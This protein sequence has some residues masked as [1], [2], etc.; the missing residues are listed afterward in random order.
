MFNSLADLLCINDK[1]VVYI[2]ASSFSGDINDRATVEAH[3]HDPG[4]GP[5]RINPE[6]AIGFNFDHNTNNDGDGYE[7]AGAD[8]DD[9]GSED[10]RRRNDSRQSVDFQPDVNESHVTMHGHSGYVTSGSPGDGDDDYESPHGGGRGD[11]RSLPPASARGVGR[12]ESNSSSSYSEG[13]TYARGGGL[14]RNNSDRQAG[15]AGP[16]GRLA[17]IVEV[18]SPYE[19]ASAHGGSSDAAN[20][21]GLADSM[22]CMHGAGSADDGANNDNRGGGKDDEEV[23]ELLDERNHTAADEYLP[24]LERGRRMSAPDAMEFGVERTLTAAHRSSN[25]AATA[26]N[27][28]HVQPAHLR[29]ISVPPN[30][31]GGG[32]GSG[33]AGLSA[34]SSGG[35]A[36]GQSTPESLIASK[37]EALLARLERLEARTRELDATGGVAAGARTP[38]VGKLDA[39]GKRLSLVANQKL[40]RAVHKLVLIN[41]FNKAALSNPIAAGS[42]MSMRSSGSATSTATGMRGGLGGSGGTRTKSRWG[43]TGSKSK[44]IGRVMDHYIKEQSNLYEY[45]EVRKKTVKDDEKLP[46]YIIKPEAT[47][48]VCWDMVMLVLVIYYS[49]MVPVRIGFDLEAGEWRRSLIVA[50]SFLAR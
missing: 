31:L 4:F 41:R 16:D 7:D 6:D 24:R 49:L 12:S 14:R 38:G 29:S 10:G 39:N 21:T 3:V 22:N 5:P 48:R 32:G 40:R 13:G 8:G 17:S 15:L 11:T 23:M 34:T 42:K 37:A 26:A 43:F 28:A 9:G 44:S 19:K 45:N 46:W 36:T 30:A 35:G 47:W 2:G 33:V 27:A 50:G 18:A 1:V 25:R 20:F